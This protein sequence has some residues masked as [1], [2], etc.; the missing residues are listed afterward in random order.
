MCPDVSVLAEVILTFSLY[1]VNS[2]IR[3][4]APSEQGPYLLSLLLYLSSWQC[5]KHIRCSRNLNIVEWMNALVDMETCSL[6]LSLV[7][8]CVR[9][10]RSTTNQ[11]KDGNVILTT[12]F[13]GFCHKVGHITN[14]LTSLF[15]I[16]KIKGNWTA[17]YF[18]LF[19]LMPRDLLY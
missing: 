6:R 9:W 1:V 18:T 12:W 15:T 7:C 2:A 4:C 3:L 13:A 16:F 17:L 5:P 11:D 19:A 10:R 8:V 14:L